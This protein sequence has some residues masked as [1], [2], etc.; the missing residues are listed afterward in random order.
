MAVAWA[1]CDFW[2]QNKPQN[3]HRTSSADSLE[4][5]RACLQVNALSY[6]EISDQNVAQPSLRMFDRFNHYR[7]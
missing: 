6:T 5:L 2:K 7:F 3:S 1:T 4:Q